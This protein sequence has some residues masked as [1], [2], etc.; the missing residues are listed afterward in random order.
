LPRRISAVCGQPKLPF[1]LSV[2]TSPA[3]LRI[4]AEMTANGAVSCAVE[5]L[6][7]VAY[8]GTARICAERSAAIC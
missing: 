5:L 6:H 4:H 2:I 1:P 8:P 7:G 3:S